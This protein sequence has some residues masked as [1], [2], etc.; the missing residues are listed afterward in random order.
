MIEFQARAIRYWLTTKIEPYLAEMASADL[1]VFVLVT[2][3]LLDQLKMV[4]QSN[5]R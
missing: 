3:I 4:Q 1:L 5:L 2:R